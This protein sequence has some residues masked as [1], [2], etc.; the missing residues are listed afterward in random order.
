MIGDCAF[1][2][3]LALSKNPVREYF[4]DFFVYVKFKSQVCNCAIFDNT[5]IL[6]LRTV[7]RTWRI[8]GARITGPVPVPSKQ[9]GYQLYGRF[10]AV[11]VRVSEILHEY[12]LC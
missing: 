6:G 4:R 9:L 8:Y 3:N 10:R 7:P 2:S 11:Y 1:W 12:H 5:T